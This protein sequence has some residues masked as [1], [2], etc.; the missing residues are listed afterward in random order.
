MSRG[1]ASLELKLRE[2]MYG[3]DPDWVTSGGTA[4]ICTWGLR[5]F[6]DIPKDAKSLQLVTGSDP[7]A[8][9]VTLKSKTVKRESAL[10]GFY[11]DT[12]EKFKVT[13]RRC[14]KARYIG[15]MYGPLEDWLK[16]NVNSKNEVRVRVLYGTA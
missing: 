5:R 7:E 12:V 8:V 1:V 2:R 14:G 15:S 9:T 10:G 16:Q 3:G 4:W 11:E 6:F 13:G